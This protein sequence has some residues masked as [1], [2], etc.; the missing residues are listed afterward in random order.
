MERTA[1]NIEFIISL[2]GFL[3]IFYVRDLFI[4][5][6]ICLLGLV[7]LCVLGRRSRNYQ[8]AQ[9]AI[10]ELCFNDQTRTSLKVDR[11]ERELLFSI[12][13]KNKHSQNQI[14]KRSLYLGSLT[15][16]QRDTARARYWQIPVLTVCFFTLFLKI[17]PIFLPPLTVEMNHLPS[18]AYVTGAYNIVFSYFPMFAPIIMFF[19]WILGEG[20]RY[21]LNKHD[22]KLF[23]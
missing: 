9:K 4:L 14:V 12:L 2:I 8:K 15:Q 6:F 18:A 21:K 10:L 23:G 11:A 20:R 13:E 19:M 5:L 16:D 3:T 7:S 1:R 22:G 17:T